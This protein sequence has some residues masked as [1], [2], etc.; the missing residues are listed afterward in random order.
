MN[1]TVKPKL[2]PKLKF[3][4][5]L[6]P[7]AL[8]FL[9]YWKFGAIAAAG[10]MVVAA[11]VSLGA[12][13]H[14]L[15]RWPIMPVVTTVIVVIFGSLTLVFKDS[16]FIKVKPTVLYSLFSAALFFGLAFRR[17]ILQIMFD[18]ALNL[19]EAGWRILT[20]RW[21]FFFLFLAGMNEYVWR[22]FS[23]TAWFTFKSFGFM[24]LTIVFALAQTP[25]ILR[26]EAKEAPQEEVL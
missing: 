6:G 3:A 5:E 8:F 7:L 22:N 26:H 20:W 19:T 24:P 12:S 17:P 1:Q 4:L 2:D 11:L 14:M 25:V 18:G 15:R 10:V 21:A 13:Y 9:S 16:T 23:E